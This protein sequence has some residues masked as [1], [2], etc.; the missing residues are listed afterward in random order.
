MR[1]NPVRTLRGGLCRFT[2]LNHIIVCFD[3]TCKIGPALSHIPPCSTAY[4]PLRFY[5]QNFS[6]PDF[7]LI[8]W[9]FSCCITTQRQLSNLLLPGSPLA[10]PHY[11]GQQSASSFPSTGAAVCIN[12][13][14][15]ESRAWGP[16]HQVSDA[17][18]PFSMNT[19]LK[20][21]AGCQI[22][23]QTIPIQFGFKGLFI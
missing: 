4:I 2:I 12:L 15:P 3:L 17:A 10:S 22:M 9:L 5:S 6:F 7:F 1:R 18:E 20:L 21:N 19:V 23:C 13:R 11:L 8:P 16:P 14:M